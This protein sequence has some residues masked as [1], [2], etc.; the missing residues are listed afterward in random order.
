MNTT[1]KTLEIRAP[2]DGSLLGEV[3]L[4]CADDVT[5]AL[6]TAAAAQPQWAAVPLYRRAEILLRYRDLVQEHLEELA[7]TLSRDNGKPLSQARGE[8]SNQLVAVPA[9]VERAKHFHATAFAPGKYHT[10]VSAL[11]THSFGL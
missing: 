6:E 8:I 11:I 3:E 2:Y 4:S 5:A 9:F 10:E 1:G 7:R